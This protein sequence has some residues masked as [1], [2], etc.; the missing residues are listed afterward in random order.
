MQISGN[1]PYD[2]VEKEKVFSTYNPISS[3]H[4]F[5]ACFIKKFYKYSF[6]QIFK[7]N[8]TEN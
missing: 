7:Q 6:F 3:I 4:P 2:M 5:L 1:P 8:K